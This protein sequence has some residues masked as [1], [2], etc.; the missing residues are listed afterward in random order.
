MSRQCATTIVTTLVAAM[1]LAAAPAAWAQMGLSNSLRDKLAPPTYATGTAVG[2]M[3]D[4][5][6]NTPESDGRPGVKAYREGMYAYNRHDYKHAVEMLKVAASW[7]Y[8]PAQYNLGAMYYE[9]E[10]VPKDRALGAAWLILAAERGNPYYQ[11]AQDWAVTRLTEAEFAQTDAWWGQLK[12]TYG[13]AVALR[14]AKTQWAFAR[15][16]QT[17]TRVGG[18]V[19]ALHVG[20]PS[21]QGQHVTEVDTNSGPVPIIKHGW[22]SVLTGPSTDGSLVY[23]QFRQSDNPYSPVFVKDHGG[24]VTLEPLQQIKLDAGDAK[25]PPSAESDTRP[26]QH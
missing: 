13:D 23:Q 1:A 7:A 9:G 24:D 12:Q 19:G 8:K 6:S 22:M 26:Q 4:S 2:A 25:A 16:Q 3:S 14:R 21:F 11:A 17:G 18:T 5:A 20:V 15:S 10:G